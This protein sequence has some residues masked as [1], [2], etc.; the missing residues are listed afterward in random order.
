MPDAQTQAQPE[1]IISAR[2]ALYDLFQCCPRAQTYLA[3]DTENAC[4]IL[5]PIGCKTWS[6]W[7][8]AKLK[9]KKLSA[10]TRDARPNRMMTL[11]VDPQLYQTPREAFDKT[12]TQV[13]E[14][15]R[16]IRK[17]FGPC[18]Y[19]RVTELTKKGWPHYHLLI[20]SNFLPHAWVRDQW[21]DLT[22]AVIVD[23]RQV[24]KTFAAYNYLVKYLS[25]LHKIEWTE[26]HVSYSKNFFPEYK[27]PQPAGNTLE[28]ARV[29]AAHPT[30]TCIELY[31]GWR[32]RHKENQTFTLH[33]PL[34][35]W[36]D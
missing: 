11:T 32:V 25:K 33:P 23:L 20:R 3:Y 15:I 35:E 22:G 7:H 17:R 31:P 16:R 13:P 21:H 8:C 30:T 28:R 29:I 2:P 10:Q 6:C 27:K 18:E 4:E 14:L 5:R 26:R 12:R 36:K 19:L 34:P 24:K 9:I 1:L